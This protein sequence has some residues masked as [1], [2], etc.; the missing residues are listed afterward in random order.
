M[1][2]LVFGQN[3]HL[4]KLN[5]VGCLC[6]LVVDEMYRVAFWMFSSD[7]NLHLNHRCDFPACSCLNPYLGEGNGLEN[8]TQAILL[9]F[10]LLVG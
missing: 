1:V 8:F 4:E 7:G 9:G 5:V 10:M 3:G 6:Y 2:A